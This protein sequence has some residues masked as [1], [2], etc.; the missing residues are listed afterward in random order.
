MK[1]HCLESYQDQECVWVVF[2]FGVEVGRLRVEET[3][4]GLGAHVSL[5]TGHRSIVQ[6]GPGKEHP[7]LEML[8]LSPAPFGTSRAQKEAGGMVTHLMT[9]SYLLMTLPSELL[10]NRCP[11]PTTTQR[12]H[13]RLPWEEERVKPRRSPCSAELSLLCICLGAASGHL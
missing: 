9:T 3:D 13:S 11:F 2:H 5:V 1:V 7:L 6:S 8:G 12:R 10:R 4:G